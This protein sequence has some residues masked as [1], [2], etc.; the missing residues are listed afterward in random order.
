[1]EDAAR[2]GASLASFVVEIEG[3]QIS[4]FHMDELYER[5]EKAYGHRLPALA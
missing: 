2:L 1:M 4:D 5:A 3:T